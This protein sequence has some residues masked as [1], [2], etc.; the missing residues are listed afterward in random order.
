MQ[1]TII[2]GLLVACFALSG[3]IGYIE[4]SR[5]TQ[6]PDAAS[7]EELAPDFT[8][9]SVKGETLHLADL[10]KKGPVLL[11]FYKL[12]CRTSAMAVPKYETFYKAYAGDGR[13]S[14]IGIVQNL[15]LQVAEAV[16]ARGLTFP[17]SDDPDFAT[18]RQYDIRTTP[19]LVLVGADGRVQDV[20]EGWNR[21]RA[22]A[23]SQTIASDLGAQYQAISIRGDGLPNQRP[24]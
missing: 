13:F 1:K 22:N 20:A 12:E 3:V 19:T 2:R 16:G 6:I 4:Y 5:R 14:I 7:T 10:V 18:S 24:G 9:A 17:H 8:L 11:C 23:I 15:P 21:D